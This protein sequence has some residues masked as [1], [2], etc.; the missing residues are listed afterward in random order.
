MNEESPRQVKRNRFSAGFMFVL[1]VGMFV[2]GFALA[3]LYKLICEVT[4]VNGAGLVE[5]RNEAALLSATRVD[6]NRLVTVEFDA[7]NNEDLP[8]DFYPLV[9]KIKVHPGEIHEVSYFAKNNA[10]HTIIGQA[11]PGITPWQATE[12]FNKTECFCFTQQKLDAGEGKEMKLRFVIDPALPPQF[13]TITL[14]YTFMDTDR[15]S[16]KQ[17]KPLVIQSAVNHEITYKNI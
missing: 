4:G 5:Q 12:H 1:V 7:T 8:W 17:G 6:L 16:T 15:S 3:P 9:K 13:K 2:F 14:S 11:V 10:S